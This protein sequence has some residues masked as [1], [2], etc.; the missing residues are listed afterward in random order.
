MLPF[1]PKRDEASHSYLCSLDFDEVILTK[2]SLLLGNL[3]IRRSHIHRVV[4]VHWTVLV[5]FHVTTL[6]TGTAF[7]L[8]GESHDSHMTKYIVT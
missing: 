8:R 3:L 5:G 2:A 1:S 6:T 4:L 7:H